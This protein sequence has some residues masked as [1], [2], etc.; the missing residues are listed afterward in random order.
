MKDVI[1]SFSG[2]K[3]SMLA[4][5]RAINLGYNIA[6]IITTV[7]SENSSSWFHDISN[8]LL[9]RVSESI[10]VPIYFIVCDGKNYVEKFEETLKNFEKN[11]IEACVFGDI[12]IQEHRDWCTERCVNA[13]ME[14]IFPLWQE[15]REA[16]VNE[17]I[18]LNYKAVIKKVDKRFFTKEF[19]GKTL[20]KK[21]IQEIKSTG[22]DPCGEN[23][24]Y[25][26]FV[27]DGPIFKEKIEFE[28]KD[29]IE[30]EYSYFATM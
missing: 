30:N 9:K 18:D 11:G 22:A 13:G 23:G 15:E 2:G 5:H 14:A 25:H 19:L 12:D 26:T 4:L 10:D 16:L 21:L 6:G 7:D 1:V 28:I 27:Y 29:K 17:F 3:D 20:D 24:E 8:N